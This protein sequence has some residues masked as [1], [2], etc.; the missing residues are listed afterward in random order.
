MSWQGVP[1]RLL[2]A[3]NVEQLFLKLSS[4]P[5]LTIDTPTDYNQLALTV[6]ATFLG[7]IIPALIAWRTFHVNARNVKKEREEQQK[8][9]QAERAKQHIF[10]MGER[11]SQFSSLK[12]DRELQRSISQKTINAQVISS[13][14]QNW[15]NELRLNAANYCALA[16]NHYDVKV[17][18][19]LVLQKHQ[20]TSNDFNTSEHPETMF[21][22]CKS[23]NAEFSIKLDELRKSQN[24][25]DKTAFLI[26]LSL[27]PEEKETQEID[28]LIRCMRMAIDKLFVDI[29]SGKIENAKDIYV[30]LINFS[31]KFME[32]IRSILKQEWNRVKLC[33]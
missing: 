15:I 22:I 8:F 23:V 25:I 13:N 3:G 27:N 5:K 33:E 11:S 20:D 6:G 7:G 30:E 18:Y 17:D 21:E 32:I 29:D 16:F 14:R 31:D 28:L 1:F 12:E 9:L 24:Q 4:L 10:M 19:L 2:D 26:L